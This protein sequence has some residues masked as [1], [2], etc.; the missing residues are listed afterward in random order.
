MTD[1]A[2]GTRRRKAPDQVP[3]VTDL[4]TPDWDIDHTGDP[5]ERMSRTP[6]T[7]AGETLD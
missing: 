5:E 6:N 3:V 4:S 1:D 7:E 2:R